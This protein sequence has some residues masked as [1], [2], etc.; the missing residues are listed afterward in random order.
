M[1]SNL[2]LAAD[3]PGKVQG[4]GYERPLSSEC[5]FWFAGVAKGRFP[6][7]LVFHTNGPLQTLER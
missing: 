1:G 7:L 2:S 5:L 3:A 4:G 6:P